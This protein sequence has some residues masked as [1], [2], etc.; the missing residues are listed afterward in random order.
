MSY[1]PCSFGHSYRGRLGVFSRSYGRSRFSGGVG[2]SRGSMGRY[3]RRPMGQTGRVVARGSNVSRYADAVNGKLVRVMK[4]PETKWMDTL[5]S[6]GALGNSA[7]GANVWYLSG[8]VPGDT[9]HQRTGDTIYAKGCG[10]AYSFLI[11]SAGASAQRVRIMLVQSVQMEGVLLSGL[12]LFDQASQ[13]D[14]PRNPMWSGWY[15]IL[16]DEQCVLDKVSKSAM[17]GKRHFKLQGLCRYNGPAG[18]VADQQL[19]GFFLLAWSDQSS[20][21]PTVGQIVVRFSFTD[22]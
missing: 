9:V 22:Q 12:D 17:V 4:A 11:N 10:V 20:N 1:R 8:V 2:K 18:T 3:R 14:P 6:G 15:K 13:F 21:A 19:N 5:V 7:G 16:M